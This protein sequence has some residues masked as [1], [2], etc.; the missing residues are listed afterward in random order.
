MRSRTLTAMTALVLLTGCAGRQDHVSASP[1]T[2]ATAPAGATDFPDF[3]GFEAVDANQ[4]YQSRPYFGGVLFATPNGMSCDNNAMNSLDDPN[5]VVLS[6][7]G[8]RP[9]RGPGNW[10]VRVATDKAATIEQ[11][12]SKPPEG[13]PYKLLPARHTISYQGILCGV[14]DKGTTACRVGD[15]GFILAPDKT[16]LF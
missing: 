12:S 16:T 13:G 9:D 14:D 5:A 1:S 8:P 10:K 3:D 6:C 4:F 11:G 2:A 7:T 15:H